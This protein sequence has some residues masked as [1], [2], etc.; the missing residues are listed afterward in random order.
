VQQPH[1]EAERPPIG[2]LT[3]AAAIWVTAALEILAACGFW[4]IALI[5]TLM[6]ILILQGGL[7]LERIIRRQR[8]K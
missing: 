7:W 6:V 1:P 5:G 8:E 4:L 2:G 3:S